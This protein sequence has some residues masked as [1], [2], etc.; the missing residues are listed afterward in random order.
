MAARAIVTGLVG[1]AAFG[2]S[3]TNE[4]IGQK[5]LRFGIV[6]LLHQTLGHQVGRSQRLP[7]LAADLSIGIAVGAAVVV[8]LN[9][10]ASKVSLVSLAHRFDQFF[11]AT[12]LFASANH[13]RRAV[14]IVSA[15]VDTAMAPEL[16]EA[17][18]NVGL[19][20]LDQVPDVDRA[21]GVGQGAGNQNLACHQGFIAKGQD[22][23]G[24]VIIQGVGDDG[25]A[26]PI[27]TRRC[28]PPLFRPKPT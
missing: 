22:G 18:P 6:E 15:D 4:P 27:P 12:A 7:E 23:L 1:T 25:A 3:A 2:T 28:R 20:V 9:V 24:I 8:K 13:D 26:S 5:G 11:L 14:R 10:K 17:D 21:V 16:L 19:D